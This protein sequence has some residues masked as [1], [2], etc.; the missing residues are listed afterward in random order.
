MRNHNPY[1]SVFMLSLASLFCLWPANA[2]AEDIQST[3]PAAVIEKAA[4]PSLTVAGMILRAA[5]LRVR[6][7]DL[8][9][10][11]DAFPDADAAAEAFAAI[12]EDLSVLETRIKFLD[13][14]RL[15]LNFDYVTS[16][17]FNLNAEKQAF[18]QILGPITSAISHLEHA[19]RFW[20]DEQ[21]RWFE[22]QAALPPRITIDSVEAAIDAASQTIDSARQLITD[23]VNRLLSA[24]IDSIDIQSRIHTLSAIGDRFIDRAPLK[25]LRQTTPSL[26]SYA[27]YQPFNR[28]IWLDLHQGIR[29]V[30]WAGNAFLTQGKW[31][32]TA[33][34]LLMSIIT[35]VIRH[36]RQTLETHVGEGILARRPIAAGAFIGFFI[37]IGAFN[38]SPPA[39]A[40]MIGVI[41]AVSGA[42]L[43]GGIE[44]RQWEGQLFYGLAVFVVLT[45][46]FRLITLP[47]PLFRIFVSVAA[48]IAAV[49]WFRPTIKRPRSPQ[50]FPNEWV[51]RI[52][53]ILFLA[54]FISEALGHSFLAL[55]VFESSVVTLYI[56][57]FGYVLLV[58]VRPFLNI[59][60]RS[61]PIQRIEFL[62]KNRESI[63]DRLAPVFNI[64]IAI[65]LVS[66]LLSA[67]RVYG[68]LTDATQAILS[69]GFIV[70]G[71]TVTMGL[72]LV[73]LA[74]IYGATL[75]SLTLQ[76]I[77]IEQVFPKREI[78]HGVQVSVTRILHYFIIL[79]GLIMALV[80]LGLNLTNITI[81]G[82][83]LGIGIGFGLQSIVNNFVSGLILLFEQSVKVGD[84]VTIA[85]QWA[86]IKSLGPRA[87]IVQTFDQ[88]EIIVPNSDM[89][90]NPVTNWTLSDRRM[91]IV[92]P[93]GVAYGSDV[94]VVLQILMDC[95]MVSSKVSRV[96]EPLVMFR[97]FGDSALEFELHVWIH[98]IDERHKVRS[99]LHQDLECRLRDA[100][101]TIA[102]PQRDIH[103][104]KG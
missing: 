49:F 5:E 15:Y 19:Q 1:I 57:L 47:M 36:N 24:Q 31:V 41:I 92:I 86:Q 33:Q 67:W 3:P 6:F 27:Y 18:E 97:K 78:K 77:L 62:R 71:Y 85:G 69:A 101:I 82:G 53:G 46:L 16:W 90:V 32:I 102:F 25:Y 98:D 29:R 64:S 56:I 95:A 96:P 8:E 43:L 87:T 22:L 12:K 58:S 93:V 88:S 52:G 28:Q 100:G 37:F 2:H 80:A 50:V 13:P 66:Y 72:V 63:V 54:I 14:D 103:I 73:A 94:K 40:L 42:A 99:A 60:F 59:I 74:C 83:A 9:N 84:Y 44:N 4:S 26:F 20:E 104:R 38:A 70:K 23:N 39:W 11:V 89:I 76:A 55:Y 17:Q 45:M 65:L 35:G 34:I 51:L 81:I 79:V 30:A 10:R 61:R 21:R 75:L 91:R 48:L 68:R 7:T